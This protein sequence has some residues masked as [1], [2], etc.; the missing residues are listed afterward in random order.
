[1]G[2]A[3]GGDLPYIPPHP[4]HGQRA[5]AAHARALL[6]DPRSA[7]S[8][9]APTP[10]PLEPAAAQGGDVDA[11]LTRLGN[12]VEEALGAPGLAAADFEALED[13]V[14]ACRQVASLQPDGS[15]Q[16]QLRCEAIAALLQRLLD[17]GEAAAAAAGLGLAAGPASGGGGGLSPEAGAYACHVLRLV[18]RKLGELRTAVPGRMSDAPGSGGWGGGGWGW[19]WGGGGCGEVD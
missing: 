8:F 16:P 3:T 15:R 18:R 19:G 12:Q 4:G 7:L 11:A 2:G 6:A 14:A 9:G 1:M 5:P 17:A 13:L 10:L